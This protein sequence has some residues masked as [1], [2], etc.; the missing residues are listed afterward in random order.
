MIL[1]WTGTLNSRPRTAAISFSSWRKRA[2]RDWAGAGKVPANKKTRARVSAKCP[3]AWVARPEVLRRAWGWPRPSEYLRACHASLK[4]WNMGAPRSAV[5]FF[6]GGGGFI[7]VG[8]F[9]EGTNHVYH[10]AEL[11]QAHAVAIEEIL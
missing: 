2:S 7:L 10:V 11:P 1:P 6:V 4:R 3:V 5:L 8:G 9:G